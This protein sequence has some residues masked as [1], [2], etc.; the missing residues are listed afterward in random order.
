MLRNK[1][2][3]V[4]MEGLFVSVEHALEDG[5]DRVVRDGEVGEGIDDPGAG[6]GGVLLGKFVG[7]SFEEVE[8]VCHG[9]HGVVEVK[10]AAKT[11]DLVGDDLVGLRGV[12]GLR[13]GGEG[14][15]VGA[16][17]EVVPGGADVGGV[18]V[19]GGMVDEEAKVVVGG[20][21]CVLVVEGVEGEDGSV[22]LGEEI[23]LAL[24]GDAGV[25]FEAEK[26]VRLD[27]C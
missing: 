3:V 15:I 9:E 22:E 24:R 5:V 13:G 1:A 7:V 10:A 12:A 11:A 19:V 14:F 20:L 26:K 6:R 25:C 16:V 21:V 4:V 23:L 8:D 17:D 2:A 18:A 27:V